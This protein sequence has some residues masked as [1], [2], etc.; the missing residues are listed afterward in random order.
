MVISR[1][2]FELH[3]FCGL[4]INSIEVES[5][6]LLNLFFYSEPDLLIAHDKQIYLQGLLTLSRL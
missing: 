2:I 3:L 4:T 6:P 5:R 1:R